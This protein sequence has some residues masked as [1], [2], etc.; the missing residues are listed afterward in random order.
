MSEARARFVMQRMRELVTVDQEAGC[1]IARGRRIFLLRD[2]TLQQLVTI[3]SDMFG[4]AVWGA[5]YEAG[6]RSGRIFGQRV[7]DQI[8]PDPGLVMAEILGSLAGSGWGVFRVIYFEPRHRIVIRVLNSVFAEPGRGYTQRHFPLGHLA[9]VFEVLFKRPYRGE[10]ALCIGKNDPF[11]E[12]VYY[13]EEG[14]K[15]AQYQ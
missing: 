14:E 12:F 2:R 11:C 15:A 4:P 1:L 3:G 13:P 10:E 8:G 9:G 5:L 7:I 6:L